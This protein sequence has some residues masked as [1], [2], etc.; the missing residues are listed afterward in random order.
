MKKLIALLM[1]TALLLSLAACS[2]GNDTADT[3]AAGTN[4]VVDEAEK[5]QT[6]NKKL[7]AGTI[8]GDVYTNDFMGI[9]FTKPADW[10]YLT[11][12]EI[13]QTINAGQELMDT[14]ALAEALSEKAS[15]YDMSVQN[16]TGG[17]NVLICYENTLLTALRQLTAD[18]YITAVTQQL[19][20]LSEITYTIGETE[21]A[22]LGEL[23]FRK[24]TA[25]AEVSGVELVQSYYIRE[26][27]NYIFGIIIT[28]SSDSIATIEAMFN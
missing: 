16:S 6:N 1:S 21:D 13:A 28:S 17:E 22:T 7:S 5:E 2:G 9:T 27:G 23:S 19:N 25:T 20:G 10:R 11:N 14:N 24:F 15:Y 4:T 3:T 12:E 26:A 8:D 18:E